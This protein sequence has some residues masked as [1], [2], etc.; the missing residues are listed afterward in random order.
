MVR[1]ETTAMLRRAALRLTALAVSLLAAAACLSP[2]LPLP[3]PEDPDTIQPSA[4]H[5]GYWRVSGECY[6][7]AM[8]TL[9]NDRTRKGVVVEDTELDAAE[10]IGLGD[11]LDPADPVAGEREAQHHREATVGY[12]LGEVGTAFRQFAYA[13]PYLQ[14]VD[15][16]RAIA[17]RGAAEVDQCA[18]PPL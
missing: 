13:L 5:S 4:E 6:T 7:G 8:V 16:T 1:E 15:P 18:R 17:R 2:T 10:P 11:H 9:F 14:I 3:P 12:P